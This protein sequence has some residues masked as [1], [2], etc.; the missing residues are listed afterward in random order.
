MRSIAIVGG[1]FAGVWSAIAAAELRD[2]ASANDVEI[3]LINPRDV[4]VIRPRLYEA[5]PG[6]KT[7]PLASVLDPIGVR[8]RLAS[9]TDIDPEASTL[10]M[11]DPGGRTTTSGYDRLVLAAGSR[12]VDPPIDRTNLD[13]IDTVE[14]AVALDE[15]LRELEAGSTIVIVGAGFTGIELATELAERA[16]GCRLKLVERSDMIGPELGPGPRPVIAE[17]LH[18]LGVEVSTGLSLDGYDGETARLS[19]GSSFAADVVVWTAGMRASDLTARVGGRC[20]ELGRLVVDQ[21]LRVTGVPGL[22]AAGDTA[23]PRDSVGHVVI[24][25][26]Q[27]AMPQGTCAGYNAMADLLGLPLRDLELNPYRTCLDLGPA[28]AV[29]TEGWDREVKLT[30]AEAKAIKHN[31][32]TERIYPRTGEA[33]AAR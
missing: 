16:P 31:I 13:D 2:K 24:Q 7:V 27:H 5:E 17:A 22:F 32:N 18:D 14:A 29:Y 28:G 6:G 12:L 10:S 11:V 30:G 21:Q 23:A 3:D 19:D 4:L 33:R 25:S 20:D 8:H 1:G 15:R 26:C 9:V